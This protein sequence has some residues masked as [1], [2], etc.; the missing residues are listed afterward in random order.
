MKLSEITSYLESIAPLAYQES[1]D[2]SGL[3]VGDPNMEVSKAIVSLDCIED[4]V[5]EAI[6]EGANLIISH[7][8]IV[9][10]GLKR[11]TGSNYIEKVVMKAIKNDIALYAIHT[12]LDNVRHGVSGKIAERLGLENVQVLEPKTGLL[13]KLQTFVP[14]DKAGEVRDALFAAGAGHIGNYSECSFNSEG[15]GTFMGND[16]SNAYIGEKNVLHTEPE[17]KVEVILPTRLTS[18]ILKALFL[19]HPY[20]EVAYELIRIENTHQEVGSGVIG[21]LP[22]ELSEGDFLQL[23]KTGL[24]TKVVRHTQTLGK[25]IKK[26]ALCGGSGSFLLKNA[27]QAGADAFVTADYKYH[28]FFDAEGKILIADVGHYESEQFTMDLLLGKIQKKFPTFAICLTKCN[29]NP[30]FYSI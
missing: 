6:R 14:H 3:L 5:D 9:F 1:Y 16:Q 21:E 23:L 19:A 27:L 24:Q 20:E 22:K 12:N 4:V 13:S 2:N 11:F 10:S 25:T 26:V 17:T 30:V 18:K 28:Q 7:H 15:Y 8:P 29:T